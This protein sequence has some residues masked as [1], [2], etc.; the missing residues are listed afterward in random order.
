MLLGAVCFCAAVRAFHNASRRS[1][2][3]GGHRQH[4]W[5]WAGGLLPA[6]ALRRTAGPSVRRRPLPNPGR[7]RGRAAH[8]DG[9]ARTDQGRPTSSGRDFVYLVCSAWGLLLKPKIQQEKQADN[10]RADGGERGKAADGSTV[11]WV[12]S[13]SRIRACQKASSVYS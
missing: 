9:Q 5:R 12:F 2:H 4:G 10:R 7:L 3:A 8:R 6:G 11:K 1:H 13:I